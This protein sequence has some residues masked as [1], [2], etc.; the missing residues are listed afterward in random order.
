MPT[1]SKEGGPVIFH[2]LESNSGLSNAV[3]HSQDEVMEIVTDAHL[4]GRGGAGF[5][6]GLKWKSAAQE[7]ADTRY[8]ICN[9]D[10]G[11]PGTF[12]DRAILYERT[13]VLLEGM[14]IAG[15]AV[16]AT[17]GIIYLRG[18]YTYLLPLIN[19]ALEKRRESGNLGKK[20][21]GVDGFDFDIEIRLGSGAYICGEEMGLIES[22]EGERGE[23]R[24]RPPYPVT[25]GYKNCPT[26]VN[27]VETFV[28]AAHILANGADWFKELGTEQSSGSK[29]FSISG[30]CE[31]PGLYEL[32][33]GITVRQ[34][35]DM[36]GATNTKAVQVGGASGTLV[37]ASQ[38]D[39]SIAF[40]GIPTG[41][42]IMIFNQNR[43]MLEVAENFMEFFTEESC[44]QCTPCRCG[45][46]KLLEGIRMLKHGACSMDELKHLISLSK[47]MQV[48]SKC[49]LGRT[50]PNIFLNVVEHFKEETIGR[51]PEEAKER[52]MA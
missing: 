15:Y 50:S 35:I 49:G 43:D 1:S 39:K 51:L 41:G 34:L 13:D 2:E 21:M 17:E 38:F 4:R 28:A 18:E 52:R 14:T 20:I 23:P 27:N 48:T 29:L 26:V 40:E 22:L 8:I 24:N 19:A 6:T 47:S 46:N 3:A 9:A 45:T 7:P 5:P 31:K 25:R 44:G 33:F 37:P 12:K 10:E 16:G 42:S 32:P 11:E 36:T 30:D